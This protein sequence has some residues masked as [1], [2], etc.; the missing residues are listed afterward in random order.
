M[1]PHDALSG[2]G[3]GKLTIAGRL[4]LLFAVVAVGFVAVGFTYAFSIRT[5]ENAS[6]ELWRIEKFDNSIQQLRQDMLE[7]RRQEK[8]FLLRK[9]LKYV[10]L[11]EELMT[12][13]EEGLTRIER[14]APDQRLLVDL[15]EVGKGLKDYHRA[16]RVA[17]DAQVEAGL[18]EKTGVHGRLRDKV[19]QVEDLVGT[20]DQQALTSSMLMM[21]RHEKDFLQRGQDKYIKRMAKEQANF[22]NLLAA[23]SGIPQK[24]KK[25]IGA[26][27]GEY[28]KAFLAATGAAKTLGQSVSAF[29]ATIDAVEPRLEQLLS[30]SSV[31]RDV[32]LQAFQQSKTRLHIV[33]GAVVVLSMVLVG[34][35]IYLV[36]RSIVDPLER[37]TETVRY[38]A[39]GDMEARV[40]LDSHDELGELADALDNL[41]EERVG[42]L[43]RTEKENE[44]LNEAVVDLLQAV[45]RLSQKDLTVKVPVTEDLTGP[46]A[47]SL[48]LLTDET[49]KVLRNV[50]DVAN[51]VS[52]TSQ[53][54]KAQSDTVVAVASKE[55][56]EVEKAA[57]QLSEASTAMLGIA[58]L[59][60]A[61]NV[62]ADKAIKTTSTAQ[63][64]VLGTVGGITSIR[65]TIRETE[66]RIKRLGERSQ[67]ISGVVNLINTIAERTHILALNASMHAA[68]AGEAGRGFAVV[69]DEVQR[70][71]ENA[72]EATSEISALV[73]NI[74]IETAD[75]VATMNE[76]ISQVVDGTQ[77]AEQAGDQMSDT[78]QKTEE[79]VKLIE[80]IAKHSKLQ[81]ISTKQL[82][83][84]ANGIR[85]STEQTNA[86]LQDQAAKT[87]HLVEYARVLLEAVT[88]FT[89]PERES[90]MLEVIAGSDDEIL[91]VQ[92]VAAHG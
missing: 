86:E 62:A 13:A 18:N 50:V 71:A 52:N 9:D 27:L 43:A 54:V 73:N 16:F 40:R 68:S 80:Q 38:V 53:G 60:Q 83:E 56:E 77:L 17:V 1:D 2:L 35:T 25:Q 8:D 44:H 23:A 45:Y 59:A 64:T 85:A 74:Q 92:P 47:D 58:K 63:E 22:T 36:T 82:A 4:G 20:Y 14:L 55:R 21:R 31:L 12:S 15:K 70:L 34:L 28:Q 46:V 76:A 19:H 39:E 33:F 72:R 49:V 84:L 32:T 51:Q 29:Q 75:T 79:L 24:H 48:N 66:K 42:H 3:A 81:A 10:G 61:C 87:N 7:A 91:E 41:L 6:D 67:E 57:T 26:L 69:A 30:E 65:D 78:R 11:H 90:D 37:V 5:E 89:L 88:V